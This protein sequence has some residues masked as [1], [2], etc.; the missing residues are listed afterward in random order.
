MQRTTT[1][2]SQSTGTRCTEERQ[3]AT[4]ASEAAERGL[5]WGQ[6]HNHRGSGD[7]SEVQGQS[8]VMGSGNEVPEKLK[9][10]KNSYKQ[11]LR[12]F[13]S[14]SHIFTYICLCFSVLAGI[15]PLSLRNGGGILY[16]LPPPPL[17]CKWGATAP[18]APGSTTYG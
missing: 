6:N 15:V 2:T 1:T 5:G 4:L 10:F 7:S 9:N 13:G 8:P 16:R 14:I 12:I 3:P 11:I 18:S 17:V